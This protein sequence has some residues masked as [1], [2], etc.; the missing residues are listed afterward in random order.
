MRAACSERDSEQ[1]AVVEERLS[2]CKQLLYEVGDLEKRGVHGTPKLKKL[3]DS[4]LSFLR[5]V[6]TTVL[7]SRLY[8]KL[9]ITMFFILLVDTR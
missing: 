7:V 5:S 8:V 3:L 6:S 2:L 9:Q 4:E 1:A